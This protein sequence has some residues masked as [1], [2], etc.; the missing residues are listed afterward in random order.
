MIRHFD[1]ELQDLKNLILSMGGCVEKAVEEAC[2]A[3]FQKKPEL[4]DAVH[5]QEVRIN[6]LQIEV[7]QACLNLLAKQAPVA[8]DLRLVMAVIKI[9]T[10]L[11]RMGDQATNIA[12]NSADWLERPQTLPQSMTDLEKMATTVKEMVKSSL[13]AFVQRDV[14]LSQKVLERDDE[15]DQF[16]DK[17]F[18]DMK[19]LMAKDKTNIDAALDLILI[20]RNLERLA[21]HATN[22]AEEVVFITTGDD[23]RHGHRNTSTT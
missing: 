3:L 12:Y 10:D 14:D 17:I 20:A 7:D 5:E 11:E 21:D 23:I 6:S 13:D 18:R 1:A 2:R 15:V 16:K 8:R 9:N 19:L 4:I 22:I